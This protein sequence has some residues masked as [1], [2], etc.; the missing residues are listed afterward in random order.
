MQDNQSLRI[1]YYRLHPGRNR[2]CCHGRGV[3]SRDM[4]IFTITLLLIISVTVL[5]FAFDCRFL[6]PILTPAV[7]ILA[8]IQFLYVV[9]AFLRT[10]FTDPGII[11]RATR[12]EVEWTELSISTGDVSGNDSNNKSEHDV[13]AV[14]TYP[15]GARTRQ[16]LIGDHL[17]KINYCHSCRIFRPPRASHCSSCD[18]CVER[19][20]HHCPWIGNCVG[21]RNYRYF[22]LFI[23]SLS[24]YCL[25]I[26]VFSI[27]NLILLY[28]KYEDIIMAIKISPA[29]IIDIL[30]TFS[31]MWTVFG[32]SGYHTSL[33]C[34]GFSTHEDIRHFPRIVKQAGH[35]NPYSH[36]NMFYNYVYTLCGPQM[37]SLL[38]GWRKVG[39]DAWPVGA[40]ELDSSS[41]E[42]I[43]DSTDNPSN[44]SSVISKHNPPIPLPIDMLNNRNAFHYNSSYDWSPYLSESPQIPIIRQDEVSR[45]DIVR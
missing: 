25:Y 45:P 9:T 34:R 28:E 18:N 38:R 26:L 8:A 35:K 15:P 44:V 14:R 37:P 1:P 20:D 36:K 2:F 40:K 10:A 19:F 17:V 13:N 3:F 24:I 22:I 42:H 23:Y 31:A 30:I 7:P 39:E 32:L 29:S 43:R 11:P 21:Q 27:V 41:N 4:C 16:I 12:P 5:F 33:V 6:T